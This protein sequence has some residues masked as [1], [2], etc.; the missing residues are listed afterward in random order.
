MTNKTIKAETGSSSGVNGGVFEISD[1]YIIER[2]QGEHHYG[3][4]L[5][6]YLNSSFINL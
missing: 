2:N 1:N 6:V 3:I 5:D 4:N